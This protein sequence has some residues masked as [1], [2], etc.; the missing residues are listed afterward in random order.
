MPDG[1]RDVI[2]FTKYFNIAFPG[3]LAQ[4]MLIL[5]AGILAGAISSLIV[6]GAANPLPF[7]LSGSSA[8]VIIISVPAVLTA[9]F[10]KT[11]KRRMQ[12]K[13]IFVGVLVVTV[14][15]SLLLILDSAV[16]SITHSYALAD[17]LV[18][19]IN[20]GIYGYWFI[21]NKVVV[22]LGRS[23]PIV[24]AIQPILNV[25]LYVPLGR[26]V[27]NI[28]V[29]LE[30]TL[31]KLWAGMLVF[32]AIGYSILYL[33][34]RPVKKALKTS[35]IDIISGMIGQWLYGMIQE[36]DIF[37]NIGIKREV[38][39]DIVTI[40]GRNGYKAIFV[41][42]DIHYG[43]YS[44][45]GG[46]MAPLHLGSTIFH[47][48]NAAPFILH[49]PVNIDDN[50][51]NTRQVYKISS[52]IEK[53]LDGINPRSFSSAAGNVSIGYD[54]PCRVIDINLGNLHLLTLTKA[55]LVTEDISREVGKR[56]LV[57]AR[58]YG[59][60]AVLIDAHNSRFESANLTELR[61]VYS[62]SPYSSKYGNAIGKALG[63]SLVNNIHRLSFG[64]SSRLLAQTLK[65]K[66]LGN[67]YTSAAVF[68]FGFRKF[69]IILFDANN[70]LPSLRDSLIAHVKG[71]FGMDAEI[72]TTDTH[73]VNSISTPAS[74]VL[75][76][77][78]KLAD[79][80]PIIDGMIEEA[81][82]SAEEVRYHYG[83]I[84]VNEIK[85]WGPGAEGAILK[86]SRDIIRTGKLVVP[87]VIAA[88]FIAAAW[89]IYIV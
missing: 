81:S 52:A 64:A 18:V 23:Y 58:K 3:S 30:G 87:F 38:N 26:Y 13:H 48:Y 74:N 10:I 28:S 63:N 1:N 80:I 82:S 36:T 7:L 6:H 72:C 16:F 56:L 79:M 12:L 65:K 22:A 45:L 19:L 84:V 24:A 39:V 59:K 75:G 73:S 41:E 69:C 25:L 70:M 86:A 60:N 68:K 29:P 67:G 85:V 89:V 2:H 17:V 78:T 33:M 76:R 37:S 44:G 21:I 54:E 42:P 71:K 34:D 9:I 15:Y 88:G 55:P 4:A 43:P 53:Y 62:G 57:R 27:L 5:L 32:L 49:G 77:H 40:R 83:R 50:P 47:K 35:G 66:D 11:A 8:G 46:S 20:A 61:G 51:I 14:V 31:I